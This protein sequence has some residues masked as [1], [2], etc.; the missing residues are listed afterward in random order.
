MDKKTI[1]AWIVHHSQKL[2]DISGVSKD[3]EQLDFAGK[4]GV[5]LNSIAAS[6][7]SIIRNES[8]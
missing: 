8:R 2:K 5:V 6:S 4:C 3:Y 7:E 1:G